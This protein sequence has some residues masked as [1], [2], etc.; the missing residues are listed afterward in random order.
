MVI[1]QKRWKREPET[2]SDGKQLNKGA[3]FNGCL[4]PTA[5][6][7]FFFFFF[8][9]NPETSENLSGKNSKEKILA[10]C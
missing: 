10:K 4:R 2:E 6:A 7:F 9:L 1:D 5:Q 8:F 3:E